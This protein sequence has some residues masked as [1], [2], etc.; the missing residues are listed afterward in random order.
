MFLDKSAKSL[1]LIEF[2]FITLYTVRSD[3]PVVA[4]CSVARR[5][6]RMD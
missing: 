6:M 3:P 1:S 5:N 2:L 4:G